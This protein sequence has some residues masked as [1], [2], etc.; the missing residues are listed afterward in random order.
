MSLFVLWHNPLLSS[1]EKKITGVKIE[2][3]G[4]EATVIAYADDVTI[5]VPKPED[6]PLIHDN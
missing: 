5:V 1:L 3:R 2:G 6:T 4:K